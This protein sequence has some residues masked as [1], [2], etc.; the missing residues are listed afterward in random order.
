MKYTLLVVFQITVLMNE[1]FTEADSYMSLYFILIEHVVFFSP[2][3][4]KRLMVSMFFELLLIK[5]KYFAKG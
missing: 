4:E 1:Q 5:G 3:W 2:L